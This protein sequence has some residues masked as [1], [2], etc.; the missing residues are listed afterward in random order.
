VIPTGDLA[1]D[2]AR[3]L[4]DI[5]AGKGAEP[6]VF[7]QSPRASFPSPVAAMTAD[8]AEKDASGPPVRVRVI[9]P[10]RVCHEG[11]AFVG[12]QTPSVPAATAEY[13]IKMKWVERVPVSKKGKA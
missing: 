6:M 3:V 4:A 1:R 2:R 13:W 8:A 10:Y 12:G 5:E 9:A 7:T 11:K